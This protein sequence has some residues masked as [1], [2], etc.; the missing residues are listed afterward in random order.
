M[1]LVM[2]D[3]FHGVW[4][5]MGFIFA[6]LMDVANIFVAIIDLMEEACTCSK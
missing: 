5:I 4:G 6:P 2:T 1:D 3:H